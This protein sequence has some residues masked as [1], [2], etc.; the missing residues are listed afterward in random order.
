MSSSYE[1]NFVL[2]MAV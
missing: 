1:I 2:V